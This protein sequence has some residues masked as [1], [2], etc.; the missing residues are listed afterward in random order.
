MTEYTESAK[1][2]ILKK[3]L[4]DNRYTDV[5]DSMRPD[6]TISINPS[7][8]GFLDIFIDSTNDFMALLFEA[9]CRVKA[10]KDTNLELIM[11]R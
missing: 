4:I 2:D 3:A 6:S 5:I 10:Q 7:Q 9:I 8:D 11:S 1:I